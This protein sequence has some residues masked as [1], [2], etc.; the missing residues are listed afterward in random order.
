MKGMAV[1]KTYV[2]K[3]E[4]VQREW[5]V[6]D[7]TGKTLGRLAARVASILR[8][9]HKPEFTPHMDTGDFI[10][11][12]N[13]EKIAVTGRKLG[14]KHYYQ[15]SGYP[16]GLRDVNL[17]RQLELHPERVIAAAVRGM[18][19]KGALGRQMLKKLKI[20]VGPEHP[21]QAQQPKPLDL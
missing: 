10:I 17:A 1:Q 19:P 6:V 7:A 15:H 4:T 2:A 13:A 3:P 18:L 5:Y 12:V 21:H 14:Q 11:I 16:S 9:K 20:Y 8:G